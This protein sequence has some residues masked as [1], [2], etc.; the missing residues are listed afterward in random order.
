MFT[1]EVPAPPNVAAQLVSPVGHAP[2]VQTPAT[3]ACPVVQ[4]FP[5]FPQLFASLA[6]SAQKPKP[7]TVHNEVPGRHAHAPAPTPS[8]Y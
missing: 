3:H 8:Q 6:S 1:H 4:R 5:H 2:V 7:A